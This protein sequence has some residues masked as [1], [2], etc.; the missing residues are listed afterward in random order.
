MDCLDL[1]GKK[2]SQVP[3]VV[4]EFI[5]ENIQKKKIE[6]YIITGQSE[7]MKNIVV[8]Q[9]KDYGMSC[10]ED[11]LNPGKMVIKLV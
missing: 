10:E 3:R 5:W 9:L 4:D 8:N 1:H 7:Q 2:H 6:A 11:F